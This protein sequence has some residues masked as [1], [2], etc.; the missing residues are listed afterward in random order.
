MDVRD[1]AGK[2]ALVTGSASGI[3]RETALALAR[4][5]ADLF[6]CD[7]NEEGLK[8]TAREV[9][10][11]GRR[12]MA[13]RVDVADREAMRR[14]ADE[15]HAEVE[16]VDILVNNAGVGL[17]GG[18]LETSLQ[19]WEW[20]IG[21]N[22]WGVIHGLHLFAPRMVDRGRGGH[23]VNISSAA[24]YLASEP[25]TA[26]STTKFAVLGLSEAIQSELA[27]HGIGVTAVCPGII[28]TPIVASSPMRGVWDDPELRKQ[29]VEGYRRRGYGPERVARNI[30]RAIQRNRL[31]AP[32]SPEAWLMYWLKRLFPGLL[33]RFSRWQVD[34]QRRQLEGG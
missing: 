17:G 33:A 20:I 2:T 31:V 10:A 19:D 3:G 34:R 12:A 8:Q 9:E 32:I 6:L 29:A 27:R 15:V 1:L 7:V 18:V 21:V 25:L 11:L 26:Y 24:G 16:G 30:L 22:L 23:V 4:R 14:F 5:G 28:D 13:R